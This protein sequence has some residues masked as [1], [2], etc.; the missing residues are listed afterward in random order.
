M[1]FSLPKIPAG[2]FYFHFSSIDVF[3]KLNHHIQKHKFAH[4]F[5]V[6]LQWGLKYVFINVWGVLR[7]TPDTPQ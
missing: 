3:T 1:F 5:F 6:V 7:S 2:I 4:T